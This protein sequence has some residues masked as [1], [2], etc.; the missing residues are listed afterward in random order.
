LKTVIGKIRYHVTEYF[1]RNFG[2]PVVKQERISKALLKKFIPPN[3]LIIDCG[4]HVGS[5]SIELSRIFRS[6]TIY[7]FEP[8]DSLYGKLCANT[9]DI[10]NIHCH[11]L[12]LA[13]RCGEMGF[14][15]S[16]GGSDAS[17]SLLPPYKHLDDHPDVLFSKA[18]KVKVL[19]LDKWCEIN[20]VTHIDFLWLDMQGYE[21][22][23]LR[24]S[25][26][27]LK[28]VSAIHTEVSTRETYKGV[29]LYN[30]LRSFLEAKG[31]RVEIE[32][33]PA[34]WD[35]GNVLFVRDK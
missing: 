21:M 17:S 35:M 11:R 12:A 31:F 29:P 15:I 7:A 30:E 23:M 32:A 18:S 19:T 6:A 10:H 4:A 28:R 24:A 14:Y 1:F 22:A 16:E 33:L 5:D 26:D 8:L 25:P 13:D 9:K 27:I 20:N 34:G 2:W 3:A